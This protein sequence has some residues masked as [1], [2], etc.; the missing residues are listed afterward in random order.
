MAVQELAENNNE[1]APLLPERASTPLPRGQLFSLLLLIVAEPLMSSSIMPYIN[2]LVN[3]LPITGGD[4]RKGGYYVGIIMSVYFV[5]MATTVLQWSRLSDIIGRKPVLIGGTL[6]VMV[7][8]TLFGLSQKFWVLAVSRFLAGAL[9][10]NNG[11]MKSM[12]AEM[13]DETNVA[14]AF[15]VIPLSSC[16]GTAV[17]PYIG[18]ILSRPHD[19]WPERFS[20]QF[21]VR[22]PY[23]LPCAITGT[24]AIVSVIVAC[25]FLKETLPKN[26]R[27]MRSCENNKYGNQALDVENDAKQEDRSS[28]TLLTRP[29]LLT[30]YSYGF[31]VFLEIACRDLWPLLYTTPIQ[32]GGLG[33]D[34]ARM[35]VCMA[36]YGTLKGILQ[37][38]IPH[39][40]IGFLGLR[41]SYMAFIACLVPSFLLF[42]IC[43]I[44]VQGGG[45]DI[46]LWVLVFI[47]LLSMIGLN[48]AYNCSFIYFS[49]AASRGMVGATYGIT[50]TVASV[51]RAIGPASTASLL[52]FSLENNIMGGYGV[53]YALTLCTLVALWLASCLPPGRWQ[54]EEDIA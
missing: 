52:S 19:R 12:L 43:G 50:Q 6:G 33:L 30:I 22:Y 40:I 4:E 9:N 24:Y 26:T 49:S 48:M 21:W 54:L 5:G 14:R 25:V 11:V 20:N 46:V 39:R 44:H 32:F 37:L 42:P 34:P 29:V 31:F 18:G 2:E 51:L 36:V 27:N 53:F 45:T 1:R 41:T 7:T 3:R 17:G 10:G 35:G 16:I 38:T 15:V 23:L 47:Q 13:T 8:T 28:H